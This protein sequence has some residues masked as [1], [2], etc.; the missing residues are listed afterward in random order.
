MVEQRLELINLTTPSPSLPHPICAGD[1]S[2]GL[3]RRRKSGFLLSTPAYAVDSD[4]AT[5]QQADLRK[6]T[7][8]LY[9]H[10]SSVQWG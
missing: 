2:G 6:A 8:H 9:L 3:S 10:L 1:L 7:A 5:L 4:P